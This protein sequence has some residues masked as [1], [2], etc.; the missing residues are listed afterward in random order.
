MKK[1][2][3]LILALTMIVGLCA[4]AKTGG[5]ATKPN[6]TKSTTDTKP[7]GENTDGKKPLNIMMYVIQSLGTLSCEDL[8]YAELTKFCE[9]TGST[10]NYYECNSDET[11]HDTTLPE[12]CAGGEYDVI[13]TGYYSIPEPVQRAAEMYPDQKWICLLYTSDAAD[14]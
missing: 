7:A 2:V 3:A 8:I 10:L 9:E 4:C 1:L 14:E 11:K 5:D 6:D 12:L 13:V